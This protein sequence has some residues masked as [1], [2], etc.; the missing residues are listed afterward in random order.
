[1]KT[2]IGR[3]LYFYCLAITALLVLLGNENLNCSR[4][5]VDMCAVDISHPHVRSNDPPTKRAN[6]GASTTVRWSR[7][8]S[9]KK[10]TQT[11]SGVPLTLL[12]TSYCYCSTR[13][14]FNARKT[15][16]R[17]TIVKRGFVVYRQ[18][19]ELPLPTGYSPHHT[20]HHT[21]V[22]LSPNEHI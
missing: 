22:N 13:T 12:S 17:N 6:Y 7:P 18:S 15:K 4:G 20:P 19:W 5:H 16:D 10:Q 3:M 8:G 9:C 21:L 2:T 11:C 14:S 1:M